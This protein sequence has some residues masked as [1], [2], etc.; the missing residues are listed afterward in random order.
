MKKDNDHNKRSQNDLLISSGRVRIE[1]NQTK[2]RI[3]PEQIATQ[4]KPG[5]STNA[6][7]RIIISPKEKVTL[8]KPAEKVM[9]IKQETHN[10]YFCIHLELL[11]IASLMGDHLQNPHLSR[12][13]GILST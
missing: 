10:I 6:G 5:Q 8:I 3:K 11:I 13:E 9:L 7:I 4:I 12:P 1:T 2:T